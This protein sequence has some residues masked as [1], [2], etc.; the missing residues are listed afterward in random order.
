M[1]RLAGRVALVTGAAS[2]IGAATA[3]RLATEGAAVLV[4]DVQDDAGTHVARQIIAGGG[5]AAYA[6]LENEWEVRSLAQRGSS[7]AWTSW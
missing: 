7:A 4:T 3:R 5:R 6:H 1:D 2:G